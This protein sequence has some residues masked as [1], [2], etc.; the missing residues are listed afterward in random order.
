MTRSVAK[1]L[2]KVS[3]FSLNQSG[4]TCKLSI[5]LYILA[6]HSQFLLYILRQFAKSQPWLYNPTVNSQLIP[7]PP[8]GC[9]V[10]L[11]ER[12]IEQVLHHAGLNFLIWG[13][14]VT[15]ALDKQPNGSGC[16]EVSLCHTTV[17]CYAVTYVL[18]SV[19]S[20]IAGSHIVVSRHCPS[21]HYP[22]GSRDCRRSIDGRHEV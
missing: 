13:H 12:N 9:R 3:G 18:C 17:S 21:R 5:W 20:H 22:S 8:P 11:S 14:R 19:V 10:W 6:V 7:I 4:C 15:L 16:L 2:K 1:S